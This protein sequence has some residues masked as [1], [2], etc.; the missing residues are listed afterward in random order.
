MEA[1]LGAVALRLE[2]DD[3]AL[4][5]THDEVTLV[6]AHSLGVG[7]VD[8]ARRVKDR[9]LVGEMV[10]QSLE[11]LALG[12]ALQIS[13]SSERGNVRAMRVSFQP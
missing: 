5:V 1:A 2:T 10:T 13:S 4:G 8:H 11:D 3:P 7:A 6:I 9:P 12:V